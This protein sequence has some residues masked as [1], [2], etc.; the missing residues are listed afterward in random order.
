MSRFIRKDLLGFM[1]YSPGQQPKEEM[2]KLN[3]N[4]NPYPPSPA[5]VDAM[6]KIS[7]DDLRLYWDPEASEAKNAIAD[8]YHI[9]SSRVMV[10][11]GSDEA[12][13]FALR[14]F[15]HKE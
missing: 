2:I 13:A 5:A 11:N 3:T 6:A 14:A 1:P 7:T 4:E 12:L 8:H 10:T 15:E 9:E